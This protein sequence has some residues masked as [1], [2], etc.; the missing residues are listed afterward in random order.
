MTANADR[1]WRTSGCW[2][3]D[4]ETSPARTV[5]L[6]THR[7]GERRCSNAPP[8]EASVL[9]LSTILLALPGVLTAAPTPG[10]LLLSL[11]ARSAYA[12][13]WSGAVVE[14]R[15]R[16]VPEGADA[17]LTPW[18]RALATRVASPEGVR[19]LAPEHILARADE[20]QVL[21]D[22]GPPIPLKLEHPEDRLEVPLAV[23]T[24]TD[25]KDTARFAKRPALAWHKDEV[26]PGT[27]VWGFELVYQ[28]LP[29][30]ERRAPVLVDA[31]LGSPV[32]YPLERFFY[33]GVKNADGMPLLNARGELVCVVFRQVPGTTRSL[34]TPQAAA[35]TVPAREAA[36]TEAPEM[37]VMGRL[38]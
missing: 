30:G 2:H 21:P 31:D 24:L 36:D 25:P 27:R 5:G 13:R 10:E 29:D 7:L 20:V 17:E 14:L 6:E 16:A 28:R 34:C 1:L 9:M 12:E 4:W 26:A 3:S 33:V 19:L 32:E 38:R 18:Q 15:F 22:D 37:R 23:L 35:L 8:P 11:E